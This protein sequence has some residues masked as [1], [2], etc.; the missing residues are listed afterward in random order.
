MLSA[1]FAAAYGQSSGAARGVAAKGS[2]PSGPTARSHRNQG[3]CLDAK[4]DVGEKAFAFL[5]ACIGSVEANRYRDAVLA[6]AGGDGADR[7]GCVALLGGVGAE[8]GEGAVAPLSGF[9]PADAA[10]D[11]VD[12]VAISDSDS[13][14]QGEA[15]LA[16]VDDAVAVVDGGDAFAE[17]VADDGE[18]LAEKEAKLPHGFWNKF[19]L[20]EI[21]LKYTDS[22]RMRCSR[23]LRAYILRSRLGATRTSMRNGQGGNSLRTRGGAHNARKV[24]FCDMLAVGGW[25]RYST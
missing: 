19:V 17:A 4:L 12:V 10:D 14:T 7:D 21:R 24:L 8:G 25:G 2:R 22:I 3:I 23:S 18:A 6:G 1:V 13:D 11:V 16:A 20:E 5:V 15:E 9:V